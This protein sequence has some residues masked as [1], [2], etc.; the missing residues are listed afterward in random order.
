VGVEAEASVKPS[1]WLEGSLSY[2]F[3]STQNLKDD[4]RFYLKSLPNRPAHRVTARLSIGAPLL[5]GHLEVFAQSTQF[6]NR[7]ETLSL[8]ARAFVNGGIASTPWK[9]PALT[10]SLD[11]KNLLDVQTQDID[12]YPLPPRA[13]FV[14]LAFAWDAGKK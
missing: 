1:Q 11:V 10:V 8:P 2:T 12:G 4:P 6:M 13:A 7:T 14:S 9:N 5:R 3:M